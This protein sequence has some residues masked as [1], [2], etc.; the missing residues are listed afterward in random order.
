MFSHLRAHAFARSVTGRQQYR[1]RLVGGRR[2]GGPLFVS[3]RSRS[4]PTGRRRDSPISSSLFSHGPPLCAVRSPTEPVLPRSSRQ[5][6]GHLQSHVDGGWN[7]CRAVFPEP[8]S[9]SDSLFCNNMK[10][11]YKHT[12]IHHI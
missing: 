2:G 5:R 7:V 10:T 11:L 4:P 6:L 12:C 8:H 3:P 1:Y 9:D